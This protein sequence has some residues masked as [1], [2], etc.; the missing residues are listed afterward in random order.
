MACI[1]KLEKMIKPY[2]E[3]GGWGGSDCFGNTYQNYCNGTSR[4]RLDTSAW[5]LAKNSREVYK[6][7]LIRVAT[8]LELDF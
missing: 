4:S 8:E 6:N 5:W 1:K 2:E 7:E 3:V